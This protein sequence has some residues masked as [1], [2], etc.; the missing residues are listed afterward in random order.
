MESRQVSNSQATNPQEYTWNTGG[1][2]ETL[3][4][5][6]VTQLKARNETQGKIYE[7][8]WR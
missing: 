6:H 5:S 2:W 7:M 8:S 4:S 1:N 3:L